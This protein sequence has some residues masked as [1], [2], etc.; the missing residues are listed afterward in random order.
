MPY[1]LQG[2]NDGRFLSRNARLDD[3]L[4]IARNISE[5]TGESCTLTDLDTGDKTVLFDAPKKASVAA[6]QKLLADA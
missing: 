6:K 1:S 2:D 3:A 5:A 4:S